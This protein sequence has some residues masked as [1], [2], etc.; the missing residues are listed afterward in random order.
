MVQIDEK[1]A[2]ELHSIKAKVMLRYPTQVLEHAIGHIGKSP[3]YATGDAIR[4]MGDA[5]RDLRAEKE[6]KRG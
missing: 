2:Q 1:T 5:I 6:A 4:L 3:S